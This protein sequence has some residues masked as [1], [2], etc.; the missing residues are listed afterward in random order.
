MHTPD[1]L[2]T[3][4]RARRKGHTVFMFSGLLATLCLALLPGWATAAA[5]AASLGDAQFSVAGLAADAAGEA[6][7]READRRESGYGD[8]KVELE[9]VLRTSAGAE[10]RRRLRIR[11]LEVPDDGDRLLVVFDTPKSIRG[12]ALLSYSHKIDPDDQ[13]MYLPALKRVKRIA[14]KNIH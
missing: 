12:T 6:I 13:W 2:H 14:S 1:G 7:F 9:M 10:S 8:L 3:I 5:P 11:Q 4:R